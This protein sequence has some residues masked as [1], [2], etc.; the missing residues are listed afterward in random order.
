VKCTSYLDSVPTEFR[1]TALNSKG[2]RRSVT[3]LNQM[4]DIQELRR[5]VSRCDSSRMRKFNFL[6]IVRIWVDRRKPLTITKIHDGYNVFHGI[7]GSTDCYKY[8]P[9]LNSTIPS[10]KFAAPQPT[11]QNLS[12]CLFYDH[13]PGVF[14]FAP[15]VSSFRLAPLSIAI[16]L[17]HLRS[18]PSC[19]NSLPC[20][21]VSFPTY[22]GKVKYR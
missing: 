19:I 5:C 10:C 6:P 2:R 11:P 20:L 18:S 8:C 15:P 21:G 17:V 4:T 9:S 13:L 7:D 1:S 16:S 14:P 12:T 3:L 22:Y